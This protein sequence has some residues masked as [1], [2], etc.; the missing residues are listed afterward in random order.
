M[1]L[2]FL[3]SRLSLFRIKFEKQNRLPIFILHMKF[4]PGIERKCVQL[5]SFFF[6]FALFR[7]MMNLSVF[8]NQVK[9]VGLF[10]GKC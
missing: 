5:P 8:I 6:F 4:H 2:D 10:L 7:I 3:L 1:S 9:N